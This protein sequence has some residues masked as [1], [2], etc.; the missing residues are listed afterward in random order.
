[1]DSLQQV[2][3]VAHSQLWLRTIK[4]SETDHNRTN[5][6]MTN[7]RK[8]NHNMTNHNTILK[9]TN[10]NITNH[11][12]IT[13]AHLKTHLPHSSSMTLGSTL[14]IVQHTHYSTA[15]FQHLKWSME[16][17]DKHAEQ[18]H[19]LLHLWLVRMLVG[20]L[21]NS[22]AAVPGMCFADLTDSDFNGSNGSDSGQ[23]AMSTCMSRTL[24]A[25]A[26]K[27]FLITLGSS[28][29]RVFAGVRAPHAQALT[30]QLMRQKGVEL[31]GG[32]QTCAHL[33]KVLQLQNCSVGGVR[34][35]HLF[36]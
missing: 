8:T 19:K 34:L 26:C 9:M 10:H 31:Q 24:D 22:S 3:A 16:A 36:G 25:M 14:L 12:T 20:S 27:S 2:R 11:N 7:Q 29:F 17:C 13:Q 18:V 32:T 6:N 1:M 4:H 5:H 15:E 30:L 23:S 33:T 28:S 21:Y 35:H